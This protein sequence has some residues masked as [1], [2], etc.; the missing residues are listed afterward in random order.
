MFIHVKKSYL[1]KINRS[2]LVNLL[3][4]P[5]ELNDNYSFDFLNILDPSNCDSYNFVRFYKILPY[6]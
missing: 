4:N 2:F 6:S 3:T 5:S 1:L